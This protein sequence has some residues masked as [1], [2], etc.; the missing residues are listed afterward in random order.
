MQINV[1]GPDWGAAVD[2]DGVAATEHGVGELS[3]KLAGPDAETFETELGRFAE[4]TAG[5]N[6]YR[7]ELRLVCSAAGFNEILA[8]LLQLAFTCVFDT[9]LIGTRELHN[10]ALLRCVGD[11]N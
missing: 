1:P 10:D 3:M 6:L 4:D 11:K 9:R 5:T 7:E 8:I 2:E